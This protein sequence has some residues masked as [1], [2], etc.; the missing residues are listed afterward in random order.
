MP[1]D[2]VI[3]WLLNFSMPEFQ[4]SPTI[5]GKSE[6]KILIASRQ[7]YTLMAGEEIRSC[8]I[9]PGVVQGVHY[10][11][12]IP[13]EFQQPISALIFNP[14]QFRRDEPIPLVDIINPEVIDPIAASERSAIE[15]RILS[16]MIRRGKVLASK[17]LAEVRPPTGVPITVIEE[18]DLVRVN[19]SYVNGLA[20]AKFV[21]G[22]QNRKQYQRLLEDL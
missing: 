14:T 20:K 9:G 18:E 2:T 8:L 4:I 3:Y 21:L 11:R 17:K 15:Q 16:I 6:G 10:I 5:T 19:I 22:A 7:L 1:N 13:T 12:K